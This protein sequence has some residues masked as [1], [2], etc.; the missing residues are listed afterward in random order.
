MGGELEVGSCGGWVR[1]WTLSASGPR[2]L[3][4]ENEMEIEIALEI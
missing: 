3:Q 2:P 4:W 1:G